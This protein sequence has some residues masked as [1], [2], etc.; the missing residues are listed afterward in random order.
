MHSSSIRIDGAAFDMARL[1]PIAGWTR[2]ASTIQGWTALFLACRLHMCG[3][4]FGGV[5][6]E[7]CDGASPVRAP[8]RRGMG[9]RRRSY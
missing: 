9:G 6:A 8:V 3:A 1:Q 2:Q 7:D 4:R 5:E